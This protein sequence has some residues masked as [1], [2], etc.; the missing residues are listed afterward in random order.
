MYCSLRALWHSGD[1]FRREG[2]NGNPGQAEDHGGSAVLV[3]GDVNGGPSCKV[4]RK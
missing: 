3:G 1:V 2:R 4:D